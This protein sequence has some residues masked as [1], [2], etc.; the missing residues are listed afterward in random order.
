MAWKKVVFSR[1]GNTATDIKKIGDTAFACMFNFS[2]PKMSTYTYYLD[3][4]MYGI[5]N[6]P[7]DI[8][9][10]ATGTVTAYL[11]FDFDGNII[12]EPIIEKI[13]FIF[14]PSLKHYKTNLI[15]VKY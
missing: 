8:S 2:P 6:Y 7:I 15:F 3:T 12:I 11:V 9:H 5:S 14:F 1:S 10:F 13:F 4:F